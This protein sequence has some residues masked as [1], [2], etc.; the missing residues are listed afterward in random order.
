MALAKS[1]DGIVII[2]LAG[3]Q[4]M[5][6]SFADECIGV[7]VKMIGLDTV[8]HRVKVING[9]PGVLNSIAESIKYRVQEIK[10]LASVVSTSGGQYGR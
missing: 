3:V 10:D 4:V 6:G 7:L 9:S 1:K 2:D 5:A 8:L